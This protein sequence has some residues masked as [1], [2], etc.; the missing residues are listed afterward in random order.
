MSYIL[1]LFFSTI[2]FSEDFHLED[3]NSTSEYYQSNIGPSSFLNEV[4]IVY[5]GHYN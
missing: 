3:L 1:L 2:L 5:F 4:S